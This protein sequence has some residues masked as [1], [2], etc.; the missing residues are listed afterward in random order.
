MIAD[1]RHNTKK[2]DNPANSAYSPLSS[3]LWGN[4]CTLAVCKVCPRLLHMLSVFEQCSLYTDYRPPGVPL[5]SPQW[6][7]T[8]AHCV[9]RLSLTDNRSDSS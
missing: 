1:R 5:D 9:P 8:A 3:S 2:V 7:F 4:Q 6:V